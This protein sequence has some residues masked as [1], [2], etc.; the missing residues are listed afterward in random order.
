MFCLVCWQEL[1][2][3]ISDVEH[4]VLALVSA[5]YSLPSSQ[6]RTLRKSVAKTLVSLASSMQSL[7]QA[8]DSKTKPQRW[9]WSEVSAK[10]L[11][12]CGFIGIHAAIDRDGKDHPE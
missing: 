5:Y 1:Q 11:D 4:S 10:P 7:L 8:L 3:L 12:F 9:A 6:G 2:P